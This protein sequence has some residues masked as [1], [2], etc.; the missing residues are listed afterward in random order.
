[1]LCNI[2]LTTFNSNHTI[3]RG[4]FP[5]IPAASAQT[6]H[7][8]NISLPIIRFPS[9]D[10]KP[11]SLQCTNIIFFEEMKLSPQRQSKVWGEKC[12]A[13][14][15]VKWRR[16]GEWQMW[17]QLDG[18]GRHLHQKVVSPEAFSLLPPPYKNKKYNFGKTQKI[19]LGR[20]SSLTKI[21]AADKAVAKRMQIREQS[22]MFAQCVAWFLFRLK[23]QKFMQA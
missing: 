2:D 18:F 7:K 16:M 9:R 4:V 6:N 10:V 17:D 12:D 23:E 22:S 3:G 20:S 8:I 11:S 14:C 21:V 13:K 5:D 19:F 15:V 1:M